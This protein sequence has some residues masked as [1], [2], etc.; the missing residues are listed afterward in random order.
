MLGS[1]RA[2][3]SRKCTPRED[4]GHLVTARKAREGHG[5]VVVQLGSLT[6]CRHTA[7]HLNNINF[8]AFGSPWPKLYQPSGRYMGP[9]GCLSLK[10]AYSINFAP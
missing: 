8:E 5:K 1:P 7:T 10:L 9:H 4:H 2:A 3:P 6:T